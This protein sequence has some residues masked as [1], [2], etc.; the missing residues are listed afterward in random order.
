MDGTEPKAV[1]EAAPE[2]P[3]G[4]MEEEASDMAPRTESCGSGMFAAA[5]RAGVDSV[6]VH[7]GR[8]ATCT[9]MSEPDWPDVVPSGIGTAS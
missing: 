3:G 8:W 5:A 9:C 1:A 6:D 7:G 2:E 4:K